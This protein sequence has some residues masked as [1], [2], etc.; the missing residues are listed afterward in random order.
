MGLIKSFKNF[1]NK[2]EVVREKGIFNVEEF[3]KWFINDYDGYGGKGGAKGIYLRTDKLSESMVID[4]LKELGY[5]E[6]EA[7]EN[8]YKY[9]LE[10]QKNWISKR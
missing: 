2:K 8:A 3:N 5:S 4:Y 9:L 10:I 6:E 1:F 7:S